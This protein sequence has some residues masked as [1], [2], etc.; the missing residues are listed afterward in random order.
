MKLKLNKKDFNNFLQSLM[1]Q[2]DLYAPVQLADGVSV[3]K[4]I[5]QPGEVNL[6]QLHTQKPAKDV[7]FPQSD[8]MFRY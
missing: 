4:K 6:S 5:D 1:D 3:F 2:Y 8:V 7:F